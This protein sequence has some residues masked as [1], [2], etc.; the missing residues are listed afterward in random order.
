MKK[1]I[2]SALIIGVLAGAVPSSFA[3]AQEKATAETVRSFYVTMRW[4]DVLG[5]C[6]SRQAVDFS[7]KMSI[8]PGVGSVRLIRK[9]MFETTDGD[10]ILTYN[11]YASWKSTTYG[12]WDGVKVL[13]TGKDSDIVTFSTAQYEVSETIANM[14]YDRPYS[15]VAQLAN[16]KE[17]VFDIVPVK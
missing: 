4:G 16:D 17:I 12:D 9:A 14:V 13:V 5:P 10:A 1:I 8:T 2:V 3:L 11:P 6:T 15:Y 7:G